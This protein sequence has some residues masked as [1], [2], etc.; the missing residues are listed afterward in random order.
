MRQ[1]FL[2][3]ADMKEK[4]FWQP[5]GVGHRF[6]NWPCSIV[7]TQ[8]KQNR[9]HLSMIPVLFGPSGES[10]NEVARAAHSQLRQLRIGCSKR[11]NFFAIG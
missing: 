5:A 1:Y 9:D 4:D 2:W 6:R 11:K 7:D 3:C 10:L 8:I